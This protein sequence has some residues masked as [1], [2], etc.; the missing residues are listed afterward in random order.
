MKCP[1]GTNKV[2]LNLN[3]KLKLSR[4]LTLC[5]LEVK[6]LINIC[7]DVGHHAHKQLIKFPK[8]MSEQIKWRGW[9]LTQSQ[10]YIKVQDQMSHKWSFGV[11]VARQNILLGSNRIELRPPPPGDFGSDVSF[12]HQSAI[13]LFAYPNRRHFLV[14]EQRLQSI[15]VWKQPTFLWTVIIL[16]HMNV[17]VCQIG[18]WHFPFIQQTCSKQVGR[19]GADWSE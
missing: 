9:T 10:R 19:D 3:L 1:T 14:S 12:L 13:V 8:I 2:Y 4:G 18:F 17:K 6:C 16:F 11:C 15:Q 7:A 5:S